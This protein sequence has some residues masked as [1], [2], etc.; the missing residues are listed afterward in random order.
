MNKHKALTIISI[1]AILH[2]SAAFG[3]DDANQQGGWDEG[4]KYWLDAGPAPAKKQPFT[5]IEDRYHVFYVDRE[6]G[7]I[8]DGDVAAQDEADATLPLALV[9]NGDSVFYVDMAAGTITKAGAIWD[10]NIAALDATDAKQ[11]LALE[12]HFEV[13]QDGNYMFYVDM[14]TGAT[15][16]AGSVWD[17]NVAALDAA[18]TRQPLALIQD[19][20]YVFYLDS[21]TGASTQ[22]GAVWDGYAADAAPRRQA[23]AGE[24]D[25]VEA[26]DEGYSYRLDGGPADQPRRNVIRVSDS[27]R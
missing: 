22:A 27:K 26:W 24:L 3:G 18:D 13:I 20:D 25:R 10:G 7:A 15:T 11:P 6:T 2:T 4:Y 16:K 21:E 12:R 23:G 9:Q 5:P 19:G 17:G 14:E 8:L 1:V